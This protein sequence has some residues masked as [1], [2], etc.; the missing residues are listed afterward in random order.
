MRKNIQIRPG[1]AVIIFD[2]NNRV[3]LQ[4]RADV[5]LWGIPS[6]HVEPGETVANAAIREV[7]E[8]T[9][10]HVMLTRLIG[11]YSDPQSQTFYYPDGRNIHFVTTCFEAEITGGKLSTNCSETL[12]L[13]YFA[14]AELP[15]N[16]LSMHPQWLE[17]AL[18]KESKAFIR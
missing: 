1:V 6:G 9:G 2:E 16:L 15:S 14:H 10:L 5:G 11:I 17:D 4:K 3:L 7:W 13:R 12:A 18:A 8:E